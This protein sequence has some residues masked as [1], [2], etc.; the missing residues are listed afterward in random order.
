MV[1]DGDMHI[2]SDHVVF[3]IFF[4]F[5][6]YTHKH[7]GGGVSRFSKINTP[8][9][10]SKYQ[11]LLTMH[12]ISFICYGEIG[13]VMSPP[14]RVETF[15]IFSPHLVAPQCE[16]KLHWSPERNSQQI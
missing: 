5:F 9:A 15:L 8:T 6:F 16:E 11:I 14:P 10:K 2:G 1:V 7:Y 13:V 12:T 3:L 4:F